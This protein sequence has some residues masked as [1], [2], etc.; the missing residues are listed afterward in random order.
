MDRHFGLF[1]GLESNFLTSF[2]GEL[3]RSGPFEFFVSIKFNFMYAFRH[4]DLLF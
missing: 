4:C 3:D 2:S 1:F